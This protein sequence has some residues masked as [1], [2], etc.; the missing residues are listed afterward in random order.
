[1]VPFDV[2]QGELDD[3][4][5]GPGVNPFL[6]NNIVFSHLEKLKIILQQTEATVII[7]W[8]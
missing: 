8:Q 4:I 3:Q 5:M 1:M 2:A 7:R 6:G